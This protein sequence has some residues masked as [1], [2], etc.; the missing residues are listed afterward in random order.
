MWQAL[1]FSSRLGTLTSGSLSF[2]NLFGSALLKCAARYCHV[3]GN[4]ID[5]SRPGHGG[6]LGFRW[7]YT[8]WVASKLGD[9]EP[10]GSS[11]S[12]AF[13]PEFPYS[14]RERF[15]PGRKPLRKWDLLRRPSIQASGYQYCVQAQHTVAVAQWDEVLT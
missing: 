11:F 6:N 1:S 7:G 9:T 8:P 4:R 10:L 15:N 12:H 3:R 5:Q 14:V 13:E 2:L